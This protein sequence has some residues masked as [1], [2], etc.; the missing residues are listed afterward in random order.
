MVS[1][2]TKYKISAVGPLET[3]LPSQTADYLSQGTRLSKDGR[4]STFMPC[5]HWLA[6]DIQGFLF[7]IGTARLTQPIRNV[8]SSTGGSCKGTT[9][10]NVSE[11][12][13]SG[14]ENTESL[15]KLSEPCNG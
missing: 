4:V 7:L 1:T 6:D 8:V 13:A 10:G 2:Y 12:A 9:W 5:L 14:K 15:N 3:I 11:R